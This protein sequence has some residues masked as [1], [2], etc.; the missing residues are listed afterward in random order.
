MGNVHNCDGHT[1][2]NAKQ[3]P[4]RAE[5]AHSELPADLHMRTN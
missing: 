5:K 3:R 1:E 4:A 2:P